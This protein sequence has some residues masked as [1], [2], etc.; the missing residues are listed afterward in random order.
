MEQPLLFRTRT[1]MASELDWRL[2]V[3]IKEIDDFGTEQA[4]PLYS[5]KISINILLASLGSA[6]PLDFFITSPTS[7]ITG[8]SFPFRIVVA[9]S[10]RS[11]ITL[12]QV[13]PRSPVGEVSRP[14]SF[15]ILARVALGEGWAM[16]C[17]I[18]DL[19]V[20]PTH[21]LEVY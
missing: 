16:I 13:S 12:L 11:P 2:D 21:Q 1:D 5:F 6:R 15:K 20:V 3:V 7:L 17:R 8:F 19:P 9:T 14:R 4:R 10:G 18:M